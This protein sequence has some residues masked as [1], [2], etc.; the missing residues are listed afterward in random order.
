[1][2]APLLAGGDFLDPLMQQKYISKIR[3][4]RRQVSPTTFAV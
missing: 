4:I 1:M 2:L 3:S